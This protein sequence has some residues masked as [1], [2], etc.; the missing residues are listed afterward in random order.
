MKEFP[1]LMGLARHFGLSVGG[2]EKSL[3]EG[4]KQVA[5]AIEETAKEE[6]GVYQDAIG[7]YPAWAP[8]AESTVADRIAKGFTPDDPLLRTGELRDSIVHEV[9]GLEA[10]IGS[11]DEVMEYMEFGTSKM[12]PRPVMGPALHHNAEK[13]QKLIGNAAVKI[14]TDGKSESFKLEGLADHGE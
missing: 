3:H 4:L 7:P 10:I 2:L 1:D 5:E 9:H 8:L 6:L 11:T 12:P 13:A 14:L